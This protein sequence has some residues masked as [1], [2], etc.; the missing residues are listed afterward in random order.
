MFSPINPDRLV[1]KVV[2]G[3]YRL[4]SFLGQGVHG[5]AYA[6]EELVLGRQIGHC[7]LKVLRAGNDQDSELILREFQAISALRHERLVAFRG[8]GTIAAGTDDLL[9]Q[10]FYL[11][12]DLGQHSLAQRLQRPERMTVEEMTEVC[13]HVCDALA[14]LHENETVHRDVKPANIYR[15]GDGWKLG[16]FG[17]VR[18]LEGSVV[19]GTGVK[20]TPLYM[21]PEVVRGRACPASDLWALGVLIQECLTGQFPYA[22]RDPFE[23]ASSIATTAPHISSDL[24]APFDEVVQN[25]LVADI[26]QRWSAAQVRRHL[27]GPSLEE[28]REQLATAEREVLAFCSRLSDGEDQRQVLENEVAQG[29]LALEAER[30]KVRRN[31]ARLEA[32]KQE[33]SAFLVSLSEGEVQR[34]ALQNQLA[35]LAHSL[36]VERE[37][38][39]RNQARLESAEEEICALRA[40]LS[41]REA[42]CQDLQLQRER[43][44]RSIEAGREEALRNQACLESAEQEILALR[45]RLTEGEDQ[46]LALENQL[47]QQ[48]CT[49]HVERKEARRNQARLEAQLVQA[50]QDNSAQM[51]ELEESRTA[52]GR[53]EATALL[54]LRL[55]GAVT[56][57]IESLT[58][59]RDAL[60]QEHSSLVQA[61]NAMT[62]ECDVLIQARDSLAQ[63]RDALMH[64]R[65][66][67]AQERDS[68]VRDRDVLVQ[69]RDSLLRAR[70]G[71]AHERDALIQARN[72]STPERGALAQK[73]DSVVQ[74]RDARP[75]VRD[76]LASRA[77]ELVVAEPPRGTVV[78]RV[79]NWDRGFFGRW[80]GALL[81]LCL[82]C[83][84]AGIL[85]PLVR[86]RKALVTPASTRLASSS[87]ASR[88]FINVPAGTYT[89]G[90]TGENPEVG[91][92]SEVALQA[93]AIGK[94]EVT[95]AEYRDFVNATGHHT[96]GDWEAYERVWGPW[97]PVV[98]V[99]WE[100][101]SAFCT[102]AGL[103]LPTEAE[104]EVAAR[105]T[106]R[107][108]YPW[109]SDWL[110]GACRG[111]F[112][113]HVASPSEVGGY[114]G[115]DS[116]Y[117]VR[118]M[119]G[120]VQ[121]W[122]ASKFLSYPYVASAERD[123][124]YGT[125]PRVFRGGSWWNSALDD[126][127][128]VHRCGVAPTFTSP[129]LGF[130]YAKSL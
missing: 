122:C 77:A 125:E 66:A 26:E 65:D 68:L 76:T 40:R 102:W 109:G 62:R 69:E 20:G 4:V 86:T 104:W 21:A 99:S 14:Y 94:Y 57:Q 116:P 23:L 130:R 41:V 110:D 117:G 58:W 10:C 90:L 98:N 92:A 129:N 12:M 64:E 35:Q 91:P 106:D 84:F 72:V 83:L 107:R 67:L 45:A 17:L 16:D 123:N 120:N 89:I 34:T 81:P 9:D 124:P 128:A 74:A 97:A 19:A 5:W 73:H 15:I 43:D 127:E 48:E 36:E 22:A 108:L 11:A 85:W 49:V 54:L 96:A 13:L 111:N 38:A 105:G 27:H 63:L 56:R 39:R 101:A 7:A 29:R 119:A 33:L 52:S 32:A 30:E 28:M 95:N 25:L 42:V 59:E 47:A 6:A 44:K 115:D 87:V 78:V 121:E 50:R 71:L 31:Q 51:L 80:R 18:S 100:D 113:G 37:E 82:V 93:F 88:E 79:L 103:R 118:D 46:R 75:L 60:V 112:S 1:G 70:D 3:R 114:P 24:P 126:F 8:A 61:R 2:D 53:N 55:H